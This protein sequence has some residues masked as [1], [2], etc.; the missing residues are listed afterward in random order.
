[1][2]IGGVIDKNLYEILGVPKDANLTLIS[3]VYKSLGQIYHPDKYQGDKKYAEEKMKYI[4][5][6]Y[7]ILSDDVKRKEYD[8]KY[9]IESEPFIN[10]RENQ[11]FK[12]KYK[13]N[14][15]KSKI[16]ETFKDIVFGPSINPEVMAQLKAKQKARDIANL[17]ILG[18]I[19]IGIPLSAAFIFVG[20]DLIKM[21]KTNDWFLERLS[22]RILTGIIVGFLLGLF[23]NSSDFKENK[24]KCIRNIFVMTFVMIILVM[25]IPESDTKNVNINNDCKWTK[26]SGRYSEPDC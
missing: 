8:N 15:N 16:T 11:S 17:K 25:L 26:V 24:F 2:G 13:S 9:N 14:F 18:L 10:R 7:S 23:I 4:N 1:M 5:S 12:K 3:S 20:F 6:A 22:D 19:L 21:I